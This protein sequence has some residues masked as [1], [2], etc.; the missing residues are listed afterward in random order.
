MA[1]TVSI[2]T[3]DKRLELIS[4]QLINF[5]NADF[6]NELQLSDKRDH[7]DSIIVGLNLVGEELKTHIDKSN[8]R[9]AELKEALYRLNEAQHLSLI[10]SWE[11]NI[12][13]NNI[14]WT[15]Q[16]Y[17]LYGVDRNSF[18]SSFENYL[19]FI[20]P[21][22]RDFVNQKV[23]Q[24]YQ[25][26][27]SFDFFHRIIRADGEIRIHHSRGEVFTDTNGQPV[28]M[29]GTAQD[30]T[31]AKETEERLKKYTNELEYKNSEMQQFSY[32][33]SHDLQEP[34]RTITN[35]INLFAEDYKGKLDGNADLYIKFISNGAKRM[36]VLIHDLLEYTRIEKDA[37]LQDIDCNLLLK[38]II[39]DMHSTI[40][41][42]KATI[43]VGLLPVI[44]G[45]KSRINSLF[46]NLIGN[47][48]K[49]RRK[50]TNPLIQISSEDKG[51]NWLF[52]I[53]DNGIGIEKEYYD[54]IFMLFQRLH[55][56]NEYEG[57]GIGLA[58]CKKIVELRGG[59]IW[60][61]STPGAGS[62][63]YILLPKK[64]IS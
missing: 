21:E 33:A 10:G 43:H 46:Q 34:L 55:A 32:I 16:L 26:H 6:S 47:A 20:H 56:R 44:K 17:R 5:A 12:P 13:Q 4:E 49:F 39:G 37:Q 7:I 35:Y 61:E 31:S 52:K 29:T 48:I 2:V 1:E 63:F 64:I 11:W 59:R 62:S 18:D 38:D 25:N 58:H 40:D 27:K 14:E 22:D 57:T 60:V 42:N 36:Q 3:E 8:E 9:E 15:D 23:Q 19:N 41:E 28:K 54:K 50:D 30:V 45:F 53:E 24:A 51:D